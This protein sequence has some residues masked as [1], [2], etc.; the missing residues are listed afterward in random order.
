LRAFNNYYQIAENGA[1]GL[2]RQEAGQKSGLVQRRTSGLNCWSCG[3]AT[4]G[5]AALVARGDGPGDGPYKGRSPNQGG[6][7]MGPG[8]MSVAIIGAF[9]L[10]FALLNI[11]E[12]GRLD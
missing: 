6:V 4:A 2:D 11:A 7:F 8:W 3:R 12:K 5:R 10:I 1:I 9:L